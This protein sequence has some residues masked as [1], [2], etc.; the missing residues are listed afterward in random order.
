MVYNV[1]ALRGGL[2][3]YFVNFY[4]FYQNKNVDIKLQIEQ[5]IYVPIAWPI[6]L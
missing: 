4:N 6:I 5:L 2:Y 1:P 3:M